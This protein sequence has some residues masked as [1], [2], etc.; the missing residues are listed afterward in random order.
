VH[1][2]RAYSTQ[3]YVHLPRSD[4]GGGEFSCAQTAAVA[5]ATKHQS[6]RAFN[7]NDDSYKSIFASIA[8]EAPQPAAALVGGSS[9]VDDDFGDFVSERASSSIKHPQIEVF[10]YFC[11]S[12]LT[13][14]FFFRFFSGGCVLR[15]SPD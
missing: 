13:L 14:I 12:S 15:P 7:W 2:I 11:F 3:R 9:V 8:T 4:L 1:T 5:A 6:T 10:E